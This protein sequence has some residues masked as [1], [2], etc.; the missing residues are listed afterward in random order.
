MK[1]TSPK[2]ILLLSFILILNWSIIGAANYSFIWN[3][4]L[5]ESRTVELTDK[6]A[7]N[8]AKTEYSYDSNNISR[9]YKNHDF[10]TDVKRKNF[11]YASMP[12]YESMD[13]LPNETAIVKDS[14]MQNELVI[15]KEWVKNVHQPVQSIYSVWKENKWVAQRKH[16]YKIDSVNHSKIDTEYKWL[17][18][19]GIWTARY[20]KISS[21]PANKDTAQSVAT[22][23]YVRGNFVLINTKELSYEDGKK[24]ED[25]RTFYNPDLSVKIQTK[26]IYYYDDPSGSLASQQFKFNLV[27]KTWEEKGERRIHQTKL[28]RLVEERERMAEN[29]IDSQWAN[30]G[31]LKVVDHS[32]TLGKKTLR[33]EMVFD[34]ASNKWTKF[35]IVSDR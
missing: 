32:A 24:K 7:I 3:G 23:K 33:E 19:S 8:V 18:D 11:V 21:Y 17:A 27:T 14:A 4:Y 31:E 16:E 6:Q 5:Q 15:T 29:W 1:K 34:P 10:Y 12:K 13:F 26:T 22:F 35:R 30:W 20:R 28:E 2:Y 25:K 9:A